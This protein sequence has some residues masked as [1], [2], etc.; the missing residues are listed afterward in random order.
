[1]QYVCVTGTQGGKCMD[2]FQPEGQWFSMLYCF[3]IL[4]HSAAGE[5]LV[6]SIAYLME[7]K[8]LW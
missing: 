1:M 2:V 5:E 7:I 8:M 3:A 6:N 4:P